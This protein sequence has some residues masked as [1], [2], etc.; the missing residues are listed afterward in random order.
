M[1]SR[2]RALSIAIAR[3]P[4]ISSLPAEARGKA[5]HELLKQMLAE[6]KR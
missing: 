2:D 1:D 5:E 3:V 4:L 6:R